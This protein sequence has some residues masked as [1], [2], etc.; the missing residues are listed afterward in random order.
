MKNMEDDGT[1]AY[2][3][4]QADE[5]FKKTVNADVSKL[6]CKFADYIEPG[7][8]IMDLGAGSGRDLVF[9]KNRG[10][11]VDGIDVSPEMCHLASEYSGVNVICQKIQDWNP[12]EKYN[13][14]WAN[15]SLLHL[16]LEEIESFLDMVD[17]YLTD[18]GVLFISFKE[19]ITTGLD[20][21][22]RFFTGVT[23]DQLKKL[24]E[25][26]HKLRLLEV[27]LTADSLK[28]SGFRWI[29]VILQKR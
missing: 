16:T 28:R 14:I 3:E 12:K 10:F 22:G 15:A 1:I 21:E 26:R 4:R 24:I 7:G 9:F 8:R 29:N 27:W 17:N 20:S 19:G 5:Y 11:R 13:G 6:C 23:E 25:K 18:R 2:Y